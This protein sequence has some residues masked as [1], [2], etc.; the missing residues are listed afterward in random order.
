VRIGH[1]FYGCDNE[2]FGGCGSVL[3]V[4]QDSVSA[5]TTVESKSSE[6]DPDV[7]SRLPS[8]V[9]GDTNPEPFLCPIVKNLRPLE[10]IGLLKDF[11]GRGNDKVPVEKR[12]RVMTN[13]SSKSIA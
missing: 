6:D 13:N 5:S 8:C 12:A 1:I 4:I 9:S 11:Y 3:T 2:K 7:F 10:A